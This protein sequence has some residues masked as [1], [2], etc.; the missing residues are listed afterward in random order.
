M[1]CVRQ[2]FAFLAAAT[3]ASSAM[4]QSQYPTNKPPMTAEAY[5]FLPLGAIKPAGWLKEQLKIQAAGQSGNLPSF[6]PDLGPGSGWLG[7]DGEAW[8]RGPYYM[9]G[10]VP[11]AFL[12][13][14]EKLIAQ[15]DKWISWSLEHQDPGGWLGPA[16][17]ADWWPVMVYL[18]ALTQYQ[19]ATGDKRVIPAMEKFFG[20][21]KTELIKRPLQNWAAARW[22]EMVLSIHWLYVRTGDKT[23]L[24]LPPVLCKQGL[25][26]EGHFA[27]FK[28]TDRGVASMATHGVNSAMAIKVPALMYELTGEEQHKKAMYKSME[29]LDKFHGQ[30]SGVFTCDEHYAGKNPSQ[31]TE[32]C[33]VMEYLWS[34]EN[35]I[36]V[37]GDPVFGDRLEKIAFNAMPAP[38]SPD[39]SAHQYDQ[40]AN[41]VVCKV[42]QDNIYV[43]NGPDSNLFGLEPNFG[44]CTANMHQG[45]PKFASHLWMATPEGGLAAISYAPCQL[46]ARVKGGAE[47]GVEV[48]TDYP[49][50]ETV[51][52]TIRVGRPTQF[53]LK[54]RIPSWAQG[55]EAMVAGEALPVEKGKFATIDRQWKDGDTVELKLP[56][57]VAIER[58]F[59]DSVTITRG[60]LVYGLK[61]GEQWNKIRGE[62]PHADYEVLPTT[63]WNYAL[64]IDLKNPEQSITFVK[65]KM[66]GVIFSSD[67]A[68]VELHVKGKLLP[69]WKVEHNAAGA[70]P[71]SP[72]KSQEPLVDLVLIPYGSAKLRV[73]EFPLL[74]E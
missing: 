25:D 29:M 55:A 58:R 13:E 52:I 31:G 56:M 67:G 60:P 26:W 68:P 41:Q 38:F 28:D 65:K 42:S 17:N 37:G 4:A 27:K 43:N 62:L 51:L 34:I 32:T 50:D 40:Q 5:E 6:W 35:L 36:R 11:L 69:E 74:A 64:A 46:K 10:L 53:P 14:D 1:A 72:V 49:F 61:I 45:W 63:P 66:D 24:D 9:D 30:A 44:C 2:M 16:R 54:L 73:T 12:L 71:K 21:A 33:T 22:G 70:P 18:K 7:G 59:N 47:A 23:L 3:I 8:E 20:F 57:H 15:A 39:M 48:K 19:E